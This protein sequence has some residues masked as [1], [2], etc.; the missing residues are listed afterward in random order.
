M[1]L[2][3]G[4]AALLIAALA[5]GA[6]AVVVAPAIGVAKTALLPVAAAAA[7]L[8]LADPFRPLLLLVASVPADALAERLFGPVPLSPTYALM[9]LVLGGLVLQ[10]PREPR[11]Q[12][13]VP[14]D[15][16]IRWTAAFVVALAISIILADDRGA[17][18]DTGARML[19]MVML[20][21]LIIRIADTRR[22][23]HALVL[24]LIA[25]TL[26]SAV[27]LVVETLLGVRLLSF[28]D[29][30]TW[31]GAFRSAGAS[32]HNPTTAAL[33]LVAGIIMAATLALEHPR[34][35]ALTMAAAAVGV[36]AIIYS[37]ARSALLVLLAVAPL[38]AWRHR[39]SRYLA[40][41][42]AVMLALAA[43]A[44]P[45]V[46]EGY[47]ER[48]AALGDLD[49]DYT[50]WR[51]VGY[52]IIGLD[53]VAQNPLFGVG[54]GNFPQHYLD[55]DYRY[56]PG[57]TLTPRVLHNMYLGIAAE[58]GMVGLLAFLGVVVSSLVRLT[59]SVMRA[60]DPGDRAVAA[61][62]LFGLIGFLI[63][64]V[65]TPSQF[66]KSTWILIGLAA[67]HA[68]LVNEHPPK[69]EDKDAP[70]CDRQ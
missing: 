38:I 8:L 66:L 45:M 60:A 10:A 70:S 63:G 39:R 25:A 49:R 35:R 1:P 15:P 48:L 57:R 23:V 5:V 33:I 34:L 44:L 11:A 65:V 37:Y 19:G 32:N 43:A 3:L 46:P 56:M 42:L 64:S 36:V 12:R 30:S 69:Q 61:A 4:S 54:P 7:C 68:R 29:S 18:L 47:A 50:L 24:A 59:R 55:P 40:F 14:D 16:A 67:A 27:V 17:A 22:R 2:S 21:P 9:L 20:A 31:T 51:R 28:D 26:F 52:N 13:L 6:A 62:I 53:L 58:V 41:S